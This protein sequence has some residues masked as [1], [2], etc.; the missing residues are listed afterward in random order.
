MGMHRSGTSAITRA[1]GLAG[2]HLGNE[3]DVGAAGE[4][5]PTGFWEHSPMREINDELMHHLGGTWADPPRPEPGWAEAPD[6]DDLRVRALE[7]VQAFFAG[8]GPWCWKDPR[9]SLTL[10]FWKTILP[11]QRY[12]LCVRNPLAV[13]AS[14]QKRNQLPPYLST[15]LWY[16]YMAAAILGS[17]DA[18]RVIVHYEDLMEDWDDTLRSTLQALGMRRSVKTESLRPAVEGFLDSELWHHRPTQRDLAESPDLDFASRALYAALTA[19]PKQLEP[20][21]WMLLESLVRSGPTRSGITVSTRSARDP[22][23]PSQRSNAEGAWSDALREERLRSRRS[24]V[25]LS[26]RADELQRQRDAALARLAVESEKQDA[27]QREQARKISRMESAAAADR[28]MLSTLRA[29]ADELGE[30]RASRARELDDRRASIRQLELELSNRRD[31]VEQLTTSSAQTSERC[32][33]LRNEIQQIGEQLLRERAEAGERLSKSEAECNARRA[34]IGPLERDLERTG[35]LVAQLQTDCAALRSER[36]AQRTDR[37]ELHSRLV[38]Q[39]SRAIDV[40]ECAARERNE[41]TLKIAESESSQRAAAS[42]ISDLLGQVE[43]GRERH[44][45]LR[46]DYATAHAERERLHGEENALRA[47]IRVLKRD[48]R[49]SK[50]ANSELQRSCD[51]QRSQ[52]LD[53]E[54][55]RREVEAFLGRA[56]SREAELEK[57]LERTLDIHQMEL[58]TLTKEVDVALELDRSTAAF[59]REQVEALDRADRELT[60]LRRERNELSDRCAS[61]EAQFA[62]LSRQPS[63]WKKVPFGFAR[64][65][66]R[67]VPLGTR[68]RTRART[69]VYRGYGRV[70]PASP[71]YRNF[72][73]A[74]E[75]ERLLAATAYP[76]VQQDFATKLEQGPRPFDVL[77]FPV[78]D[79]H[80][81]HQRPQHIALE[82]ARL[83]HRV[84]YFSTT[85]AND[86]ERYRLEPRFVAP[87]V[88]VM[89]LPCGGL[90]PVIYRDL[91]TETQIDTLAAGIA[92]LAERFD[93]S[94]TLSIIDHPF[95]QPLMERLRNNRVIYD[96][97]DH[98]EGFADTSATVLRLER[99]LL[100]EA[101]ATVCTARRIF[102][103]T[104]DRARDVE[105]IPNATDYEHFAGPPEELAFESDR[106]VIGYYGAIADWFDA[107][108]VAHAARALP[109]CD[110]LLIGSTFSANLEPLEGLPNV[111]FTGE[112]PYEDLPRYLHAFD[113]CIIPFRI[114]ELTRATNPV[115][116]FEYLSAGKPVVSV[117]LPEVEALGDLV[118]IGRDPRDFTRQLREAL[119]EDSPARVEER[120]AF[121][122]KNTWAVRGEAFAATAKRQFPRVSVVVLTYNQLDFT[123]A[124]L[125]SLEK[126]SKYPNWELIIVD[127]A[128]EDGTRDFL[129]EYAAGREHVEL[130]LNDENLGFAAGNNV[131]C[132]RASGDF[133]VMLNNDTFVTPGWIGKL[134]THFEENPSLALLN[135]VTNNIGN[136]ARIDIHYADMTEMEQVTAEYTARRRG[137]R[138]PLRAAAFFCVMVR[139]E[140]WDEVGELDEEFGV[141]FF[142]DDD[143]AMRV[144]KLG[145]AIECAEDVFVHHHLS[146]SFNELGNEKKSELFDRNKRYFESKWGE[147]VPHQYRSDSQ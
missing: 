28:D 26:N 37:D 146:A 9:T 6:L 21:D 96:R 68:L 86:P 95:W 50:K 132:R 122:R 120:C 52:L 89:E 144:R 22:S 71:L 57:Q 105:L 127:N 116:V 24:I 143:Y 102:D 8:R 30:Q 44:L 103:A 48:V 131:G 139:R 12:V 81:R 77:I 18:P 133:I 63:G 25:E 20:T 58:A 136:E 111:T 33:E 112:V 62:W 82:L 79:W 117:A 109:E 134:L 83:G 107:E 78:I 40:R 106:A 17:S 49:T 137:H 90:P 55:S 129:R 34:E 13:A 61:L 138:I 72:A 125:H 94:A 2:L 46:A 16:E 99:K 74:A 88:C 140:V 51:E 73:E 108:L 7:T 3:E 38:E 59:A 31:E 123:R 66:F 56:R 110:F 124:C 19:L 80:F 65:V 141:G 119:A 32:A 85:F 130:I 45:E 43:R 93:L 23:D 47:R 35:T 121:A 115:K 84:F 39:E 98:H 10:P 36:D 87:N 114:I 42:E 41:L 54:R 92:L 118:R 60:S 128:S 147:W 101:H 75:A 11:E 69:L 70:F 104:I 27:M 1:L 113:V 15:Q 135:P 67:S 4:D 100:E 91:L 142:E 145:Y 126:N 53:H 5:N 97:M 64:G 76:T 14:L 29:D